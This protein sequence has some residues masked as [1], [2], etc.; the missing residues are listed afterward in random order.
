MTIHSATY[1]LPL[2]KLINIFDHSTARP[3]ARWNPRLETVLFQLDN[4]GVETFSADAGQL[5]L[6][7]CTFDQTYFADLHVTRPKPIKAMV[8]VFNRNFYDYIG[9]V[10][11]N[12]RAA[13]EA[14]FQLEES[15][16]FAQKATFEG[17]FSFTTPLVG[18]RKSYETL[19]FDPNDF[20]DVSNCDTRIETTADELETIIAAVNTGYFVEDYPIAVEDGE[21]RID[22]ASE[23]GNRI[24]GV[25]AA[26]S[27]QGPDF[28]NWYAEELE[29]IGRHITG[30]V[31]LYT[32]PNEALIVE[33]E[34][35]GY[36]SRYRLPPVS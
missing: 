10:R 25:L 4:G 14:E 13:V 30:E 12:S 15:V 34:R 11:D 1:K 8:E 29:R 31:T 9:L 6:S 19:A 5:L 28:L 24:A 2:K 17:S 18:A 7:H 33:Q 16:D 22:V 35:A 3:N 20:F 36:R 23:A 21:F 32:S 27:V 26:Q